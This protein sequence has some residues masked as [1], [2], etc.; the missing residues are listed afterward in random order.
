METI[1]V[2]SCSDAEG[3]L[4]LD[5]PVNI[6]NAEFSVTIESIDSDSTVQGL[7][8]RIFRADLRQLS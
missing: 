7:F 5:V 6:K 8:S 3:I 4:H 1:H 2:R